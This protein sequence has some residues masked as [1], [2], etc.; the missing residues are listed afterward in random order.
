MTINHTIDDR[1]ALEILIR[2]LIIRRSHLLGDGK[3]EAEFKTVEMW[4]DLLCNANQVHI[5]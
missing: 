4:L 5:S 2:A 3:T 1:N